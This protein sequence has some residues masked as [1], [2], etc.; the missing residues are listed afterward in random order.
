MG[1]VSDLLVEPAQAGA[2]FFKIRNQFG[3]RPPR[4]VGRMERKRYGKGNI[5]YGADNADAEVSPPAR[6]RVACGDVSA[7]GHRRV[8]TRHA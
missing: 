3:R 4:S 8:N 7:L 1:V 5:T 6:Y 2:Q